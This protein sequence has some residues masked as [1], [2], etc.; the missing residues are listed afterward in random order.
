[1]RR[2]GLVDTCVLPV[3]LPRLD[4]LDHWQ[5]HA[6]T[7]SLLQQGKSAVLAGR[8]LL[9]FLA[10]LVGGLAGEGGLEEFENIVEKDQ[11]EWWAFFPFACGATTQGLGLLGL[12]FL[13]RVDLGANHRKGYRGCEPWQIEFNP[14]EASSLLFQ[15][16]IVHQP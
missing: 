10:L 7:H 11:P 14:S 9:N 1:M 4:R 6:L 16:V 13:L 15:S 12:G 8:S 5:L 3:G 2:T